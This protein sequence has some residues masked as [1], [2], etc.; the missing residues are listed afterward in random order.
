METVCFRLPGHGDMTLRHMNSLRFRQHFCDITIVASNNQ[1]FKGHK[2]VLAA[3]SPF[4]RDQF[5]LNPSSRLQVSMLYSSSVVCDLLQSCYTGMLQFSPEEIVNYLTAASYFQMEHI[6]ERCRGALEKYVQLKSHSPLKVPEE[7]EEEEE[8]GQ[9]RPVILSANIHSIASP[10]TT[11]PSPMEQHSPALITLEEE[12]SETSAQDSTQR[13]SD[14]PLQDEPEM[15]VNMLGEEEESKPEDYNVF[16]VY[17]PEDELMNRDG[18]AE[19]ADFVDAPQDLRYPETDRIFIAGDGSECDLDS[20][21]DLSF[22]GISAFRR[23]LSEP[24]IGRGRGRGRGRGLK[25]RKWASSH[26]R[27]SPNIAHRPDLWYAA[28]AG[29]GGGFGLDFS[30][31]ELKT[32]GSYLIDIPRFDFSLNSIHGEKVSPM[33]QFSLEESGAG[34]GSSGLNTVGTNEGGDESVAVV[35]STS[36]VTGPVICEHCGLT[37]PSAHSLAIHSRSTHLLYV[38]P[39]CGKHFH[40]STNLTRHMAVHR[41]AAKAHQ[42]PLCYKTFTQK[43]TL[44][45]HMNLHSGERPHRCAYCHARFAHKPALR[46]HLK[47][48]HG[49]TTGQNSLHEQEE[50]ERAREAAGREQEEEQ[51]CLEDDKKSLVSEQMS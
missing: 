29:L 26:E 30:Q 50:R 42:C 46:R 4:L 43:S 7:E 49:K 15:K 14:S 48:Q 51:K 12:N 6:V 9:A 41:G 40:H 27:R 23:K 24:K 33:N 45:D 35:G 3:C 19:K 16:R 25:K 8:E 21:E 44:I 37:F 10:L 34:E 38:C 1:T 20:A 28:T 47:E 17:I 11:R 32:A 13:N 22:R 5:L 18:E 36:S 39:C 2:V 31:E